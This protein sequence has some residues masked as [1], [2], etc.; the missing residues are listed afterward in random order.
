VGLGRFANNEDPDD[1][2]P[3]V[4]SQCNKTGQD[5]PG[6]RGGGKG[7]GTPKCF[8]K[9]AEGAAG[10]AIGGAVVPCFGTAEGGVGVAIG[11]CIFGIFQEVVG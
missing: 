11:G 5:C 7:G 9:G 4:E 10:G 2:S 6:K 1:H 3:R 8:S